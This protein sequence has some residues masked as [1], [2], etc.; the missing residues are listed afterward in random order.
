MKKSLVKISLIIT[1]VSLMIVLY[2][3]MRLTL[4]DQKVT[5][6]LFTDTYY[7]KITSKEGEYTVFT[8]EWLKN[9][10]LL[11]GYICIV[12]ML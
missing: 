2:P 5:K 4:S 8:E 12:S 7:V 3:I 9:K 10:V 6:S 1:I 11:F